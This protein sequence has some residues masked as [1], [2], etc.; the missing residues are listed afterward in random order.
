MIDF[1]QKGQ[2]IKSLNIYGL[3][4]LEFMETGKNNAR[5]MTSPCRIPSEAENF[6]FEVLS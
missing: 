6:R 4:A 3:S 5:T 2:T 1:L